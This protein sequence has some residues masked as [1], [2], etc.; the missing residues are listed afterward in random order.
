[1]TSPEQSLIIRCLK[2]GQKNR[3]TRDHLDDRPLC[4]RC[5]ASLDEL[6]IRCLRCHRVNRIPGHRVHDLPLCGRC[7][8]GL[9]TDYLA[10]VSD[11]TFEEEVLK[12]DETVLVCC[13]DRECVFCHRAMPT[14]KKLAPKYLGELRLVRLDVSQNPVLKERYAVTTTPTYLL[15]TKGVLLDTMVGITTL[16]ELESSLRAI[17]RTRRSQDNERPD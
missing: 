5:G 3:I 16:E 2:C 9:Y 14:L 8:A 11:G 1:M 12:R 6:F 15:F 13:W 10:D 17:S 7:G 4:G